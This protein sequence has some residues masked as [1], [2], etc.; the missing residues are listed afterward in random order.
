MHYI[1]KNLYVFQLVN[2]QCRVYHS[3]PSHEVKTAFG[4]I[5]I[6]IEF[7]IPFVILIFC[8]G[9]IVWMLSRRIS[10]HMTDLKKEVKNHESDEPA[11]TNVEKKEKT[12][13]DAHKEKFQLARRNTIKTILIVGLCFIVCWS[14]SEVFYLMY[15]FGYPI[16]WNNRYFHYTVLM[17]FLNS[18]VNPFIYLINYQDYQIALRKLLHCKT[19]QNNES[20]NSF[21]SVSNNTNCTHI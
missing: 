13:E 19:P 5:L 8:Y 7:L 15:N 3:W 18:T 2:G 20:Q 6:F 21:S 16:D 4:I 9:K 17:V 12:P 1:L 11:G 10:T 14:Q